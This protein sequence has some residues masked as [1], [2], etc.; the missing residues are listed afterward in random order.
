MSTEKHDEV[1]RKYEVDPDTK[2]PALHE[3]SGVVR[4]A[5]PIELE[6]VAT[7][8]DTRDLRLLAASITLRRRTGGLDDGWHL[9]LQAGGD[10]REELRA[11]GPHADAIPTQLLDRVRGLVRDAAVEPIR[12]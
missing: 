4:V 9:K 10:R 3:L 1:E 11:A 12:C 2:V 5:P 8:H 7:Y 6:Q